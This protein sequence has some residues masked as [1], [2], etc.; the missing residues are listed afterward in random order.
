MTMQE[1]MNYHYLSL[2]NIQVIWDTNLVPRSLVKE[3]ESMI[4]TNPILT[5]W[6]PVRNV[7]GKQ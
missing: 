4:W 2:P 3:A 1:K 7:T 5:K 6:S